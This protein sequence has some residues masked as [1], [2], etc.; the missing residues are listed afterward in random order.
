MNYWPLEWFSESPFV[1]SLPI[2]QEVLDMSQR[3]IAFHRITPRFVSFGFLEVIRTSLLELVR[4]FAFGLDVLK[5]NLAMWMLATIC[6]Q[7]WWLTLE[8]Q[9]VRSCPFCI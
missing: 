5:T 8:Q 9:E 4:H 7:N 6:H 3:A 1:R 2:C